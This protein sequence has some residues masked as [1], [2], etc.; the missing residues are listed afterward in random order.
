MNF[1]LSIPLVAI[2]ITAITMLVGV[3]VK[4]ALASRDSAKNAEETEKNSKELIKIQPELDR[5]KESI[6]T[7]HKNDVETQKAMVAML[8]KQVAM[9][10]DIEA[11]Q[12]KK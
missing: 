9:E 2:A 3:A 6:N 5:L 12:S 8:M 4:I 10:K 11:L 7:I 1:Q